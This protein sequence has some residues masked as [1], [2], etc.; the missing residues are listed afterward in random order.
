M[1]SGRWVAAGGWLADGARVTATCSSCIMSSAPRV[2]CW[3]TRPTC[4]IGGVAILGV[5][6]TRPT[7]HIGGGRLAILGVW[8]T[9]PTWREAEG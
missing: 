7:C 3:S 4:H 5:W 8:S 2:S 9:R 1:G 6:S